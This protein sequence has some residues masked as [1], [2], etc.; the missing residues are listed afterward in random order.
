MS[1]R[2]VT[3]RNVTLVREARYIAENEYEQI[4]KS[5]DTR[6]DNHRLDCLHNLV[7]S[8]L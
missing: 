4:W 1:V 7:S 8:T 3:I 6:S 5:P 2:K